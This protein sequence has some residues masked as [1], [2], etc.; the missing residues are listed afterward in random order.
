MI[1][2]DKGQQ[3]DASEKKSPIDVA[4]S[5][6]PDGT[7]VLSADIEGNHVDYNSK[8][9]VKLSIYGKYQLVIV[10]LALSDLI[11][12]KNINYR[13]KNIGAEGD[14]E[15]S[16]LTIKNKQGRTTEITIGEATTR[17]GEETTSGKLIVLDITET[18]SSKKHIM[19]FANR[20]EEN[21]DVSTDLAKELLDNARKAYEKYTDLLN[22]A[23]HAQEARKYATQI[24]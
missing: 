22:V 24:V 2:K 17:F 1:E 19:Q 21:I 11:L 7:F 10:P 9:I 6:K 12:H 16:S 13:S 8:K 3:P 20:I 4:A 14:I 15:C 18:D 23:H 5:Y